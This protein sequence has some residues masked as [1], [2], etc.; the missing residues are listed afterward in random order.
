MFLNVPKLRWCPGLSLKI[1]QVVLEKI[2][3]GPKI[4]VPPPGKI[5]KFH[6]L[7]KTFPPQP[8]KKFVSPPREIISEIFIPPQ[9]FGVKWHYG[10]VCVWT[11]VKNS[12]RSFLEKISFFLDKMV[13]F[14]LF[15]LAF[16][17]KRKSCDKSCASDARINQRTSKLSIFLKKRSPPALQPPLPL[18]F[19]SVRLH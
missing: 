9:K 2:N 14:V 17:W 15:S 1:F 18:T 8:E 6:F 3:F 4:R 16:K 13:S 7:A 11:S 10:S 5:Q 19:L 12:P